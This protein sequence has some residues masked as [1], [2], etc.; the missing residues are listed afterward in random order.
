MV[1]VGQIQ[2]S[3][4]IL[5]STTIRDPYP[6]LAPKPQNFGS[7]PYPVTTPPSPFGFTV[8]TSE[9]A[10]YDLAEPFLNTQA[11]DRQGIDLAAPSP[12]GD[13]SFDAPDALGQ[14]SVY[15]NTKRNVRFRDISY[16]TNGVR[17]GG[18]SLNSDA[19]GLK[20]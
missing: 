16:A 17:G 12:L 4:T 13:F 20:A 15:R 14:N 9:K 19:A 7:G 11:S 18:I 6:Q 10:N 8:T 2:S 1:V 5:T 3:E